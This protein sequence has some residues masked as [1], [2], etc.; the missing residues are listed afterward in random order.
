RRPPQSPVATPSDIGRRIRRRRRTGVPRMEPEA[1]RTSMASLPAET[2][3]VERGITAVCGTADVMTRYRAKVMRS[4]SQP[5]FIAMRCP[6]AVTAQFI[7]GKATRDALFLSSLDATALPMML[8]ATS[9]FSIFLVGAAA[10]LS[11]RVRPAVFVPLSFL[12]SA[13]LYVVEF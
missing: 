12:A 13:L 2:A 10:R 5:I 9:V 7:S 8:I 3:R 6:A 11:A 1:R 4:R